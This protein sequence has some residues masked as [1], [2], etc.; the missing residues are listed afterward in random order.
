MFSEYGMERK[1]HKT[2]HELMQPTST[3]SFWETNTMA[4]F[5]II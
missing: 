2:E 4:Y 5:M 1:G 3:N